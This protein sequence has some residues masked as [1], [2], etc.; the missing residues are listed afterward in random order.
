MVKIAILNGWMVQIHND[1]T[2][3]CGL[4]RKSLSEQN[5]L[6]KSS[7][8]K[9]EKEPKPR[10]GTVNFEKRKHPRFSADLPMEYYRVDSSIGHT[11]KALNVSEGGSISQSKWTL[12]NI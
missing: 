7:V 10:D 11:G 5:F 1:S 2:S 3:L 8:T 6:E 4:V 12:A 9:E